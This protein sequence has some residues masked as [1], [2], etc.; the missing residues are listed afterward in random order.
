MT[1]LSAVQ[2]AYRQRV[3]GLGWLG[4][5]MR[6]PRGSAGLWAVLVWVLSLPLA[7][8]LPGLIGL[9]PYTPRGSSAPL[10]I[11][12]A[13]VAAGILLAHRAGGAWVAGV[14]AGAFAGWVVLAMHTGLYGTPYGFNGIT[15]DA[16]RLSAQAQRYAVTWRSADGIVAR[17]PAEYPPLFP[18]LIGRASVVTG[19]PA[20]RL[21]GISETLVMSAT[22]LVSFVFWRRLL[23]D[24]IALAITVA[25]F[26]VFIEP[27]KAY[28]V[29]GLDLVIPWALVTFAS[30]PRGRLHWLPAGIIGGLQ[31][32]LY[33]AYLAI[34]ALGIAALIVLGWRRA[35]SRGRYVARLGGVA[36]VA[37]LTSSWYLV[38]YVSWAATHGL[39]GMAMQ[40]QGAAL[41]LNPFPFLSITPFGALTAIGLVGLVWY[42]RRAWWATPLLALV[43][44]AYVY[45]VAG[46][47]INV[48]MG[49]TMLAQYTPRAIAGLLAAAGVL[50]LGRGVPEALRRL[51]IARP[52]WL[53][54]LGIAFLALFAINAGWSDWVLGAPSPLNQAFTPELTSG[55]SQVEAA[56]DTWLPDGSYPRFAP[57]GNLYPWF[58]VDEIARD[59]RSV[60]G[61]R[62]APV[63][64]SWRE[65]LFAILPWPGYIGVD[66]QASASTSDWRSRFAALKALS[67]VKRAAPFARAATKTPFGPIDAFVLLKFGRRWDWIPYDFRGIVQFSPSQFQSRAF[68]V[69][70]LPNQ[71]VLAVRRG[72]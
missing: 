35:R 32:L 59:V 6:A 50:T 34:A 38:P 62:A 55:F 46:E 47:A 71:T 27:A 14:A 44:G 1:V 72:G 66:A 37:L 43:V 56:F 33:Q 57:P 10:A 29:M 31:I 39:Q 23:S 24:G 63:T 68:K 53:G 28:E 21:M 36:A 18:W 49:N 65:D 54:A 20:W 12:A 45:R 22:V 19:V 9:A 48:H 17:V 15:G 70:N 4:D 60:R 51:S 26:A 61:A 52:A 67:G 3:S 2:S 7:L 5:R 40:H 64:L 30:P 25:V 42:R 41:T 8:A 13:L 69:F 11:G 16:A 58:P